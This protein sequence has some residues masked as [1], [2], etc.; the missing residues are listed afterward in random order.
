MN[1]VDGSSHVP[2]DGLASELEEELP[3]LLVLVLD[4][5]PLGWGAQSAGI[6][7][8]EAVA[9]LLIFINSHLA[10]N[11]S[12][13]VAVI[14]A[15]PTCVKFLYPVPG[16]DYSTVTQK[17]S[18][19]AGAEESL[20]ETNS[21]GQSNGHNAVPSDASMYRQFRVV[22]ESVMKQLEL[23][24]LATS[25]ADIEH[26]GKMSDTTLMSGAL[27]VSLAYINRLIGGVNDDGPKVRARIMVVSVC[28]DL[29]SQYVPIMNCIFAAQK[30][31][32]PIDICKIGN[33]TGFL[34]QAADTTGGVYMHLEHPRGMIQYL[35]TAFL[36]DRVLRKH[37]V[38]PTQ[39]S[40]DFRA[41]CFCHNRIVDIGYVCNICLSIYCQPPAD[42][43]CAICDTIF[44]P[45]NLADLLK[46]PV[47]VTAAAPKKAK[48]KK[49]KDSEAISSLTPGP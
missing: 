7:L 19:A 35:L 4:T 33:N 3:S 18:A 39:S 42:G 13:E 36:P 28:S 45:R 15:H 8:R 48:K 30:M 25:P 41:A 26:N 1:A 37:L 12:N 10:L 40:I 32:V 38:L 24:L 47:V 23:L 20:E 34:E 14:A 6:S 29:S 16:E 2:Q 27:S 31:K 21:N 43:S 11:H 5:S 22:N 46:K 9:S 44:D 17:S 49:K